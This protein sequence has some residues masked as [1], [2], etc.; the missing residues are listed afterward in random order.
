[1]NQRTIEQFR[2][3]TSKAV[4]EIAE[5]YVDM[6]KK[7]QEATDQVRD[8]T[9]A[10][11]CWQDGSTD[12]AK[13]YYTPDVDLTVSEEI[14]HEGRVYRTFDEWKQRGRVVVKGEKSH[15][16]GEDGTAEFDFRQTTQQAPWE[17]PHGLRSQELEEAWKKHGLRI[18]WQKAGPDAGT[19]RVGLGGD[20]PTELPEMQ[21][22][23]LWHCDGFA[24]IAEVLR[25]PLRP[26]PIK[27]PEGLTW[28]KMKEAK[29]K[30]F[31]KSYG[32]EVG[33]E[34]EH[35]KAVAEILEKRYS[36]EGYPQNFAK[37]R[38]YPSAHI[39]AAAMDVALDDVC[40]PEG[41]DPYFDNIRDR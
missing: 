36:L 25:D 41:F 40:Y 5:A 28:A 3:H 6:A 34:T 27:E 16:R 24:G 32:M 7:L 30:L 23:E 18:G 22:L 26:T 2:K 13:H 33:P 19:V 11:K 20:W 17:T 10:L 1:M 9:L 37:V 15:V 31:A 35:D 12:A 39:H 29:Q 4:R 14:R 21:Y 8:L 38:R